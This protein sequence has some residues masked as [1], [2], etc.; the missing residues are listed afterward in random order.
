MKKKSDIV[1]LFVRISHLED[2]IDS[3]I[4]R[5]SEDTDRKEETS[6]SSD[7]PSYTMVKRSIE[8]LV[9]FS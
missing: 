6:G 4:K 3:T 7:H 9:L 2:K 5:T 1:S 8:I